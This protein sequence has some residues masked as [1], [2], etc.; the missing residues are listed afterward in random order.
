MQRP[1]LGTH[2][3]NSG[4]HAR[5]AVEVLYPMDQWAPMA[6][7]SGSS[8][9]RTAGALGNASP[10]PLYQPLCTPTGQQYW[11]DSPKFRFGT[12]ARLAKQKGSHSINSMRAYACTHARTHAHTHTHTLTHSHG[13]QAHTHTHTRARART[14][15]G[16]THARCMHQHIWKHIRPICT[17]DRPSHGP[18]CMCVVERM[19][20]RLSGTEPKWDRA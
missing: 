5:R 15:T 2:C 16:Y 4:T 12:G 20:H 19:Q 9:H 11:H 14:L 7:T 3:P 1:T 10:G 18:N 8:A 17:H 6:T 13:L